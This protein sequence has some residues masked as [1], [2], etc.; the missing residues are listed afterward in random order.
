MFRCWGGSKAG[1]KQHGLS[2]PRPSFKSLLP[3]PPSVTLAEPCT[4][5]CAQPGGSRLWGAGVTRCPQG[6]CL[7]HWAGLR[8]CVQGREHWRGSVGGCVSETQ[9]R[10]ESM[11]WTRDMC[12]SKGPCLPHRLSAWPIGALSRCWCPSSP[13]PR[14]TKWEFSGLKEI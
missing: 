12:W 3:L 8:M 1:E 10:K 7:W 5:Q 6:W 9:A 11:L 14:P 4:A 13:H 2:C